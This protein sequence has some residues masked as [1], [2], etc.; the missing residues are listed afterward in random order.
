LDFTG[1]P[2]TRLTRISGTGSATTVL[3][4]ERGKLYYIFIFLNHCNLLNHSRES[5]LKN[6]LIMATFSRIETVLEMKKTGIV[7][8]FYNPDPELCFEVARA[9]YKGGMRVFELTN[10]GDYAHE[11]FGWLNKMLAKECPGMIAGTGSVIDAPT[12]ALY[13]QLGSNFIVSPTLHE[14]IALL[15]NKRKIPYIPGC[16]TATEIGRAEELGAEVIKIFPASQLGGP[17]FVKAV[18]GPRPWTSLMP[19]G[20]VEPTEENLRGWF[21]AGVHCVGMGSNLITAGILK[22]R[23]FGLLEEKTREALKI[24][25]KIRNG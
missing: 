7:P 8:V 10:R 25:E 24:V 6:F 15:C 17:G 20:G 4:R 22:N 9:C 11:I 14:D 2:V 3:F 23:D 13:I 18:R 21:A 19:S 12:A 16:G 1:K 5:V